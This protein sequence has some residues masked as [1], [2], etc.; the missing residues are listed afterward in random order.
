MKVYVTTLVLFSI[1]CGPGNAQKL[2]N[3]RATLD[4]ATAPVNIRY[5]LE[6]ALEGQLFKV[7]LYSSHNNFSAPLLLVTGAVGD[8]ITS[9]INKQ[10]VWD[11]KELIAFDGQLSFDVKAVL[12]FSPFVIKTPSPTQI[13]KRH[14]SFVITWIGGI[15][16]E[17]VNLELYRNEEKVTLLGQVGNKGQY[18]WTVPARTKPGNY[19]QIK[20]SSVDRPD[21]SRFTEVFTIRRRIPLV[22]KALPIAGAAAVAYWLLNKTV[23]DPDLPEPKV[24]PL[25]K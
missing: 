19:H 14:K 13:V 15:S 16:S 2:S 17:K 21:N 24:P 9:G 7:Y 18:R 25:S 8:G 23:A 3:V 20:I 1:F 4:S 5:D 11:S 22:L 10:I 6:A 12:T